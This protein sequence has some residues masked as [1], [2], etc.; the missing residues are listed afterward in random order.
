MVID[1]DHAVN[2]IAAGNLHTQL[3]PVDVE[4]AGHDGAQVLVQDVRRKKPLAVGNCPNRK[5]GAS[6]IDEWEEGCLYSLGVKT[7]LKVSNGY[8]GT[9]CVRCGEGGRR[10]CRTGSF[11]AWPLIAYL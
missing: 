5:R 4:V 11:M 3:G 8:Q 6:H 2:F 10:N 9:I 7:P 1:V